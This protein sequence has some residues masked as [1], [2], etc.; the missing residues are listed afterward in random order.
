MEPSTTHHDDKTSSSCFRV[1]CFHCG[2]IYDALAAPW[3][4]CLVKERSFLCASCGRCFCQAPQSY[5]QRFWSEA[6]EAL[7]MV[8]LQQQRKTLARPSNPSPA[9]AKHPLVLVADDHMNILMTAHRL[10]SARDAG[11]IL[12]SDGEEALRLARSH[13]PDLVLT[14]ALMPRLDGRELCRIMK[15]DPA[16]HSIPVVIMTSVYTSGALKREALTRFHADG[17]LAKP[18]TAESLRMVLEQHTD[19]QSGQPTEHGPEDDH[20]ISSDGTAEKAATGFE[21]SG[22]EP[23][24]MTRADTDIDTEA[25]ADGTGHQP[26]PEDDHSISSDGTAEIA[27][28]RSE[29]SDAEPATIGHT[30]I[31]IDVDTE[32]EANGIGHQ[33][34]GVREDPE[35]DV[36]RVAVSQ[37]L[38]DLEMP[39]PLSIEDAEDKPS[40][41]AL[42]AGA[43]IDLHWLTDE[44]GGE[45][46]R[47]E[48]AEETAT[49]S[50]QSSPA[51]QHQESSISSSSGEK[52]RL[53]PA[54][55]GSIAWLHGIGIDNELLT[56]FRKAGKDAFSLAEIVSLHLL[57]VTPEYVHTMTSV[58]HP[59][60]LR[61]AEI[62]ELK[63]AGIDG[64]LVLR[65][66]GGGADVPTVEHLVG[67]AALGVDEEII[68]E[69][70]TAGYPDL[71]AIELMTLVQIGV[72]PRFLGTL[73]GNKRLEIPEIVYAKL[74]EKSESDDEL[75]LLNQQIEELSP[76]FRMK[77]RLP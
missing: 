26:N 71:S 43:E 54:R 21:S 48:P 38:P 15:S 8:K 59:T 39:I 41:Y 12:A 75:A 45:K 58:F 72:T 29:T 4:Q 74:V 33:T 25:K 67:L 65:I 46:A 23:E 7:W 10:L 2:S 18:V 27:V 55:V 62:A 17:Y 1:T 32:A 37:A 44:T 13:N 16:L 22:A 66:S 28:T 35:R 60:P 56:R 47:P 61:A 40:H 51:M 64:D 24:T 9:E 70:E 49:D 34:E 69:Y 6:P 77:A 76:P 63:R 31:D 11:V 14:D 30:G 3:C 73:R 53:D 42:A 52:T 19:W 5:K 68:S 57:E 20:S 36:A 50:K